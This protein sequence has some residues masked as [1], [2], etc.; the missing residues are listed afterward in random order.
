M[1]RLAAAFE[2]IRERGVAVPEGRVFLDEYGDSPELSARLIALIRDGDKR[3]TCMSVAGLE[4]D[5]EREPAVGDV[6]IVLDHAGEPVLLTR[7]TASSHV[8]FADVT[9]EFAAK[10]GEG[11]RTLEDWRR[12][13][14][15]FFERECARL[16]TVFHERLELVCQEFE[17]LAVLAPRNERN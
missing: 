8:A 13:H 1:D 9:A 11:D 16:G 10:E 2:R 17:L 3:A 15:A 5:G 6:A 12:G 4:A 7:V 14:R